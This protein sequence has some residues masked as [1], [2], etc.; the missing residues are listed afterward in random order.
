MNCML[1]FCLCFVV[2]FI[3]LL[4]CY[5]CVCCCWF[6]VNV[7]TLFI[8]VILAEFAG[9]WNVLAIK[10]APSFNHTFIVSGTVSWWQTA[11]SV[12]YIFVFLPSWLPSSLSS[13]LNAFEIMISII[14]QLWCLFC[15][16]VL[17]WCIF[18]SLPKLNVWPVLI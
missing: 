3:L 16:A 9:A 1:I 10:S 4:F 17:T 7:N 2:I 15:M 6:S 8:F 18:Q 11:V 5:Y 13:S 12:Y 14:S